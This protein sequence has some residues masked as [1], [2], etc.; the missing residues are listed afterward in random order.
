MPWQSPSLE[1]IAE[2][3]RADIRARLPGA[4]P[5]LRRSLLGVLALAEAGAVQGLYGYL[6]WQARQLFPDTAEAERLER[7]AGVWGLTRA[8]AVAATGDVT[9]TG[10]VGAELPAGTELE[11]DAGETY[12]TDAL[13]TIDS[14]GQATVA[15]TAA[16]AGEAGNLAA[17]ATLRL[18]SAVSGIDSEAT[19][20]AAGLSGGADAES[21]QR[22]R[23]R[24]LERIQRPP[25]GGSRDD[26]ER[27]ALEAHPDVTRA[28]VYPEETDPG[29]VTVRAVCDELAD[30]IPTA[31]VIQALEDYIGAERPVTA[32][33]YVVAPVAVPLDLSIQLTPD[34]TEVRERVT[35]A[36]ADFLSRAAEPGG[37]LYREQL[38]G[39][40][41]VAAGESRHTLSAP[42]GDVT[43]TIN[44]IATLGTITWL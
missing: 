42:A 39:V 4:Q 19:V 43:H 36:L 3:V 22:L 38:S 27:W 26:Y 9:V 14:A 15:V 20:A 25:Q 5:E 32:G 28:W 16:A 34:T 18:V 44:E 37:T 11:S 23:P 10:S 35:D 33:V 12:T 31:E 40:I 2:R 17:G 41:Y 24:L 6:D 8:A 21:D 1:Q 30:I 29:T 13:A 7:W